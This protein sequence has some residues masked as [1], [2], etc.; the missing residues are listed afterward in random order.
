MTVYRKI[1][2][3]VA[4]MSL[5]TVVFAADTI[6]AGAKEFD[7]WMYHEAELFDL[8]VGAIGVDHGCHFFE[9]D[10]MVTEHVGFEFFADTFF[11]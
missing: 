2:A 4:A 8:C 6:G 10:T 11:D 7:G 1:A 3:V 9:F 5:A